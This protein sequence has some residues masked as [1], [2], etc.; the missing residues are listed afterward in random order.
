MVKKK[1]IKKGRP[2]L[3]QGQIFFFQKKKS[4]NQRKISKTM[5]FARKKRTK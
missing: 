3:A 4:G 5:E 2:K 1:K